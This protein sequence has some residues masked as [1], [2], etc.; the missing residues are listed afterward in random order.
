MGHSFHL[1]CFTK[2]NKGGELSC[3]SCGEKCRDPV[4]VAAVYFGE[5]QLIE[6]NKDDCYEDDEDEFLQV[7]EDISSTGWDHNGMYF[8]VDDVLD[9]QYTILSRMVYTK[10][11]LV[12]WRARL[13]QGEVDLPITY[14]CWKS[15]LSL[16]GI[17]KTGHME[18]ADMLFKEKPGVGIIWGR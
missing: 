12:S 18:K 15:Y 17:W 14:H 11:V 8:E 6:D 9:V 16:K 5:H 7:Y 10:K 2:A 1:G 13:R 4:P 3:S